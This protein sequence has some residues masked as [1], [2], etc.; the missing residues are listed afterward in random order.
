MKIRLP[1][2]N[3]LLQEEVA[4]PTKQRR[5]SPRTKNNLQQHFLVLNVEHNH[6]RKRLDIK[7]NHEEVRL[8][9]RKIEG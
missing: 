7:G 8:I 6:N 4:I 2:A 3:A 5:F 9:G 1:R